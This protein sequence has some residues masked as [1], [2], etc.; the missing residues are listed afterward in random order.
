MN[1]IAEKSNHELQAVLDALDKMQAIIWFKPDGT[2]IE[3]NE[4]FCTT[5]GYRLEEIVGQHHRMFVQP[6]HANSEEYRQFWNRLERGEFVDGE[7]LRLAK[8]GKDVFLDAVY[9][10]SRDENGNVTKVVKLARNIT[11][12]AQ[13]RAE[14]QSRIDAISKSQAIVE[15]DLEGNVLTAN[16]NFLGATGYTLNELTGKNH[17][18]LVDRETSHSSEYSEFWKK[19]Q[20]GEHVTAE[21]TRIGKNGQRLWLQATYN[22]ILNRHGQAFKVVQFATD[23]TEQK[24][25]TLNLIDGV[26]DVSDSIT[27]EVGKITTTAGDLAK[28]SENQ[29]ATVEE[30]S[31]AMEEISATVNSNVSSAQQATEQARTARDQAKKGGEVVEKAIAAMEKIQDG[32][33]QIRKFIEVIDS[34]AF[35]TNLLALNAG[36]EAARAGDAGRGFAVVASEVRALA[37]R[38]SESAK[39]INALID[40]NAREVSE[41]ATLVNETGSVLQEIMDGVVGVTDGIENIFTASKEQASGLGEISVAITEI[42]KATQLNATM[43]QESSTTA[44]T[45]LQNTRELQSLLGKDSK[46]LEKEPRAPALRA[47]DTRE[48]A[49]P[50]PP[51]RARKKAVNETPSSVQDDEAWTEF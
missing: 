36:V 25:R 9:Q 20:N 30:T 10:P 2:I 46:H 12:R 15:Y 19:L 3:A 43:A 49:P 41:G 34:I 7:F 47:E 16:S 48:A 28:R 32:S 50:A 23:V 26:S 40:T 44:A 13:M 38:A 17:R 14:L 27:N 51:M 8:D 22:P 11:E 35:Q 37:Q 24:T 39:D 6:D 5:M 42:D 31:A 33:K 1:Q 21:F 4:N 18:I 45:L 29:A